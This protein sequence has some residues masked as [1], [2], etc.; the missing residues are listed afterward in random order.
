[1][2]LNLIIISII[3]GITEFLPVSSTAHI[4]I[5]SKLL[6]LNTS[7]EYIK[8]FLLFIQ[9]GALIAGLTIFTK[10]I[11]SNKKIIN[12]IIISF[13]PTAIIG[14]LL[15]KVFKSLLEGNMLILS[16]ALFIGG[17]IFIIL[18][19][20]KNGEYSGKDIEDINAK[21]ALI[22]GISQALA[23]VPGVS[24]SG[25]TIVA[26]IILG[27]KKSAIIEYTFLLA[28]PTIATAVA[29]DTYKSIEI[30]K[31][32]G[33]Y[34]TLILGFIISAITAYITLLIM[35]KYLNKISLKI[36]GWYRILLAIIVISIF[37]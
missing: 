4:I 22:I 18:D 15:Y 6:N 19:K 36:F 27:I 34:S 12:N 28:L 2:D 32:I 35:K 24:R 20:Y 37:I 29:Y 1:M 9:F 31:A 3:E 14:F 30:I 16:I 26:G 7:N 25:A 17:I 5:A 8:F 10:R 11:F 33:N 23:I 21:E 13:I